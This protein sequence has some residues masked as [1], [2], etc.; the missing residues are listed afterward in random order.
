MQLDDG[1]TKAVYL[2]DSRICLVIVPDGIIP[3]PL[4]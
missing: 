1:I 3:P 4:N 2:P